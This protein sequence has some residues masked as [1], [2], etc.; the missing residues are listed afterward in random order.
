VE[1]L[2]REE[3]NEEEASESGGVWNPVRVVRRPG[4][5]PGWKAGNVNF[6]L[7]QLDAEGFTHFAVCDADGVFPE[8]FVERTMTYFTWSWP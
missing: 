5:A 8:D 3:E 7:R 1:R 6:A 2:A 4:G